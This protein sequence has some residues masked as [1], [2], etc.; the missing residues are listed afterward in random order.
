MKIHVLIQSIQYL[1]AAPAVP[2]YDVKPDTDYL[3]HDIS[4]DLIP[5]AAAADCADLCNAEY[6]CV[7]KVFEHILFQYK[8]D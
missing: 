8:I 6:S 4:W 3:G 7:G 1:P 5:N 2:C